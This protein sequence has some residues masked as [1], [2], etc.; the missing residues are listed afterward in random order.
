VDIHRLG[1]G[2]RVQHN[3]SLVEVGKCWLTDSSRC[4][5]VDSR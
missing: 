4:A 2:L 5:V 3:R 1:K